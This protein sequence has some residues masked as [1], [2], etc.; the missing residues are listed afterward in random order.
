MRFQEHYRD[1]DPANSGLIKPGGDF[2]VSND[3]VSVAKGASFNASIDAAGAYAFQRKQRLDQRSNHPHPMPLICQLL[4]LDKP[5][6]HLSD[7]SAID[8]KSNAIDITSPTYPSQNII[9]KVKPMI[10]PK[11]TFVVMDKKRRE[12]R[13]SFIR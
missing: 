5:V 12:I 2:S 4:K 11:H 7:K 10:L 13:V 8:R 6:N 3:I 1:S 9:Q